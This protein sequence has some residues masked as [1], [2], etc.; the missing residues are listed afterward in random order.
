MAQ[1][2]TQTRAESRKAAVPGLA[3][4]GCGH[5]GKNLV[6]NFAAL[7][8]LRVLC[9]EDGKTAADLQD[10]HPGTRAC[11]GLAK[12][13][14]DPA[15]AAVV[16]ATPA[17]QHAAQVRQALEAGKDVFVEKPMALQVEEA[18]SLVNLAEQRGRILM[19]GHLLR[20]HPAVQKIKELVDG[21]KL[22][23]LQYIYSNR[24]NLG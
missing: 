7:G 16:I 19:V 1:A 2:E 5:W 9:D 10:Q 15:V 23:K 22:G 13:L 11:T 3:V 20:Y 8:A 21:G 18:R 17:A 4:V 14:T 12:V 6:R 24:L